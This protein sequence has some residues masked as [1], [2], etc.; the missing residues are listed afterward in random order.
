[1]LS[2]KKAI[3]S[4]DAD[5]VSEYVDFPALRESLKGQM[6]LKI[7]KELKTDASNP[8]GQ[9]GKVLAV[10]MVNTFIES[11]VTPSGVLLMLKS[12]DLAPPG[13]APKPLPAPESSGSD[14]HPDFKLAYLDWSRVR[15]SQASSSSSE[16]PGK[17][18]KASFLFR[19]DGLFGWRLTGLEI[20]D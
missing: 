12:G 1:M 20:D 14:R 5:K 17:A 7:D 13:Q 10:G 3:D 19:R 2:I 9:L 16:T 18:G 6:L 15:V 8:F 4:K 11:M